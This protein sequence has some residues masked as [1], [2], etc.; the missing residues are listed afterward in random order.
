MKKVG[1][2]RFEE[3]IRCVIMWNTMIIKDGMGGK[4]R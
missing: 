4:V 3:T 1:C 2:F